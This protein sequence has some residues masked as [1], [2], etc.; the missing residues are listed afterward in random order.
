VGRRPPEAWAGAIF[1][2]L[3]ALPPAVVG[4]VLGLQPGNVNANLR[5]RID[6]AKTTVST[7]VLISA[8]RGAGVTILVL[9]LMFALFAW[10]AVAPKR[11][12]RAVVTGLAV[13]EVV[14]L[15][16]GIVIAGV[17]AV[18]VGTVLLA[19]AG[20]VLLYLPRTN[21]FLTGR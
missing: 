14:M 13:F 21:E 20:A 18:S 8:F 1:L 15:V 2:T 17:D 12:G 16:A 6:A 10:L 7:D 5:A 9:A 3:A 19:A 4:A 11:G